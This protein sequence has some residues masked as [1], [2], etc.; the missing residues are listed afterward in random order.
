VEVKQGGTAGW[1][2]PLIG[3]GFF[4]FAPKIFENLLAGGSKNEKDE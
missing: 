1:S 3:Q 2:S 4:Y